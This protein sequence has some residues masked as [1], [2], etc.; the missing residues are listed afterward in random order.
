MI[1]IHLSEEIKVKCPDLVLGCIQCQVNVGPEDPALSA[2]VDAYCEELIASMDLAQLKERPK[3]AAT[4]QAYKILGKEPSR[5]RPSAEALCRRVLQGKGLYR[6]NNVVDLL[7]LVS[8]RS[9]YSI[10]GWDVSRIEGPAVL[11]I[12]REDEPYAAIGRGALNIACFPVFRDDKGAFGTP[13]S[14]SQRTMVRPETKE[15]LM[16]IYGFGY[17]EGLKEAMEHAVKLLKKYGGADSLETSVV[18]LSGNVQH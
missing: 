14:D 4:R 7:N 13:T 9:G 3:I 5:Y 2:E 10:G 6:V 15:F 8:L 18:D 12:G 1:E 16:V 11:G 17:E